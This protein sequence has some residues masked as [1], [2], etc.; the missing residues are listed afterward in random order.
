MSAYL[1]LSTAHFCIVLYSMH[2][3]AWAITTW[4]LAVAGAGDEERRLAGVQ[5]HRRDHVA[6]P[7]LQQHRGSLWPTLG[8]CA[9]GQR[10]HLLML[11]QL[12]LIPL[13]IDC[14]DTVVTG[15]V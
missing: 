12:S 3:S 8:D 11:P 7:L 4:H 13:G 1:S 10:Q 2:N 9:G 5:R 6:V 15:H 14:F